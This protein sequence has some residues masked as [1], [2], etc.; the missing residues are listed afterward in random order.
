[1]GQEIRGLERSKE[2]ELWLLNYQ[3]GKFI[4]SQFDVRTHLLYDLNSVFVRH[5]EVEQTQT[6]RTDGVIQTFALINSL[7][8]ELFAPID[9]YLPVDTDNAQLIYSEFSQ[10]AL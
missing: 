5:L 8:N 10:V 7:I 2:H 1:M 3:V 9:R 6:N 4:L